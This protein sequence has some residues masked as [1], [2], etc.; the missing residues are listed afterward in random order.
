MSPHERPSWDEY[1]LGMARAASLR[2]DC[3]R[4]RVGAVLVR[5]D[6][7]T[8]GTGYNGVPPGAPGCLSVPCERVGKALR[9]DDVC[10][11]YSD[12][13]SVH[14]EANALLDADRDDRMGA[15]LYVTDEPCSS[16]MKLIRGAGVARVVTPQ[17]L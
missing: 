9:G 3:S 5:P 4:R 11:G 7:R 17:S 13:R 16:C 1:F 14:A 8:A 6:H 10:P 12:C 2:G 15:T